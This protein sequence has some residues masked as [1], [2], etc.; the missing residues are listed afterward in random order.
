MS[1]PIR[2][3]AD[4]LLEWPMLNRRAVEKLLKDL[5]LEGKKDGRRIEKRERAR[6][7]PVNIQRKIA[8]N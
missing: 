1:L 4:R 3:I 6:Q 2:P 7:L 5:Y 8:S